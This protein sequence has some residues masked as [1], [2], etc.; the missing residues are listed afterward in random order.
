M[1]GKFSS[2]PQNVHNNTLSQV[3]H[4]HY[5]VTFQTLNF[6][7][8]VPWMSHMPVAMVTVFRLPKFRSY[9]RG[10]WRLKCVSLLS[11]VIMF[12][13]NSW[14]IL[15]RLSYDKH[16][17]SILRSAQIG[18]VWRRLHLCVNNLLYHS[19]VILI[20]ISLITGERCCRFSVSR[21]LSEN[22]CLKTLQHNTLCYMFL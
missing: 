15:W 12:R 5:C 14:W 22:I 10:A 18:P 20:F 8:K 9:D 21:P 13:Q 17:A 7:G 1:D 19:K 11:K 16:V 6:K 3:S 4:P 2:K